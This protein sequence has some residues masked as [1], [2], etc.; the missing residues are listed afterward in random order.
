LMVNNWLISFVK[1][2]ILRLLLMIHLAMSNISL[3]YVTSLCLH[4]KK[5]FRM[6]GAMIKGLET[7][8]FKVIGTIGGGILELLCC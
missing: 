2:K 1:V 5:N 3:F 6:G 7:N 8:C 4:A